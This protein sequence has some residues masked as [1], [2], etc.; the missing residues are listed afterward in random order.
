VH[1][2]DG[3]LRADLEDRDFG[4]DT[5]T[6]A[7]GMAVA[8]VR[9]PSPDL[10]L[11]PSDW[12]GYLDFLELDGGPPGLL[13]GVDPDAFFVRIARALLVHDAA[14]CGC[15]TATLQSTAMGV[16]VYA[17][18]GFRDLGRIVEYVPGA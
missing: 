11:G 8:D 10:E 17:A 7:M 13:A 16:R 18:V 3:A 4:V 9:L 15:R 6:R 12:D 14:A 1:E 2:S 5:T